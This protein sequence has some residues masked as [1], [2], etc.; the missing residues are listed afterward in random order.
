MDIQ[1]SM[2]S[3]PGPI[4]GLA[5]PQNPLYLRLPRRPARQSATRF[6][7]H[8]A[9]PWAQN[10]MF[11]PGRSGPEPPR[12]PFHSGKPKAS[13]VPAQP[14][15]GDREGERNPLTKA[16]ESRNEASMRAGLSGADRGGIG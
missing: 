4:A 11:R 12:A 1:V 7:F 3:P 13:P 2:F 15:T 14:L 10:G 5:M 6:D 9:S 16:Y 8:A